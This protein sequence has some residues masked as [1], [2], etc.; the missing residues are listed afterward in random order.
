MP[1]VL[2]V[3]AGHAGLEAAFAAARVGVRVRVVTGTLA[4][5]GQT[6]CNPSVGGVAKGHL[7]KE[8]DALGG[9]MGRAADA[10][11]IHARI[12]NRSK[13]P[14]VRSTRVQVDKRRY[15]EHARSALTTAANLEIVEGLVVA[16]ARA[17]DRIT[18]VVLSDGSTIAADAV[19]ITTGTFLGGIL[20]EGER[21]TPGGRVGEAPAQGLS[22]ELAA[23]GFPLRRLKTGTPPRLDGRTIDYANLEPQPSEDP[24]PRFVHADDPIPPPPLLPQIVCHLTW[25][26]ARTHDII[27]A[28]LHRSPM[29]SGRITGRGP[30]YC[31][32]VEDKIV[33]FADRE[34]HQVFLEPEGLDTHSVYPNGIS[35]SLPADVQA[36]LVASIPGLEHAVVLRNGYAVEY[37]A[38][39]A[40]ALDHRL[41]AKD[42]R[43]L[44]FAGQ[45][46]GT[47]GYEEAGAQGLVAGAN[48]AL[49]VLAR[50]P[51]QIARDQGYTGV[52]I[53]DL[54]TQG[55]DEPYRMFTAR[56]EFRIMLREDNAD[57]RLAE[58]AYVAGLI[59]ETRRDRALARQA[60]AEAL[61]RDADARAH[62]HA[63]LRARAE[64][65]LL[66]AGYEQ[67]M[68]DEVARTRGDASD[69]PLPTDLDYRNLAGLSRECAE[70]LATVR[71]TSTAQAARIP[72]ITPAAIV[73]VWAHARARMRRT[74]DSP[75]P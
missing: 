50:A 3:G 34:R 61:A 56:A 43:G 1:T 7:V 27:R 22:R 9:F 35:T 68:R 21:T 74:P 42:F 31:P 53:D 14:A 46:T 28:S 12:L 71:P 39:D 38:I 59:D 44:F 23:L 48:A 36:E 63:D 58:L 4:T 19:V 13:G 16:L 41:A 51:L 26:N 8:I 6:P 54:V 40:R 73:T 20:H 75:A 45:V 72:G 24:P 60:H 37:D 57:A 11:A 5:V 32:S 30:R 52:M 29:Y 62:A 70:R 64:A 15:G 10:T 65:I 55:S 49:E 25:T 47:S 33:R 69:L 18:G 66:Y 67:K 17:G 2:V